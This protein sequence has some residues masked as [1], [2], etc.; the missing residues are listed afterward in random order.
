[1]SPVPLWTGPLGWEEE[2]QALGRRGRWR[3]D[4]PACSLDDGLPN[5]SL[6]FTC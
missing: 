1:M 4:G 6:L 5:K 3:R 2:N